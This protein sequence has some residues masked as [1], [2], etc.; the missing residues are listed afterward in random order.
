MIRYE[1][2]AQLRQLLD[3]EHCSAARAAQVMGLD[4]KTVLAWAGRATYAP[5]PTP[6]R[7][8][9]SWSVWLSWPMRRPSWPPS[10][11]ANNS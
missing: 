9:P 5:R 4:V 10:P 6:K 7:P 1:Q 11:A 3:E 2:F 8:S